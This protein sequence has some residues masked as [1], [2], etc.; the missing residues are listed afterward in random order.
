[1]KTERK[2]ILDREE[3]EE[4][5]FKDI[6]NGYMVF[7]NVRI[8]LLNY[9]CFGNLVLMLKA[10]KLIK[11]SYQKRGARADTMSSERRINNVLLFALLGAGD[12][13]SAFCDLMGYEG[14]SGGAERGHRIHFYNSIDNFSVTLF[15]IFDGMRTRRRTHTYIFFIV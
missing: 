10:L 2:K 14:A 3:S 11:L 12:P 1:M 7:V 8:L 9:L 5:M 4:I 13:A 15:T 6:A